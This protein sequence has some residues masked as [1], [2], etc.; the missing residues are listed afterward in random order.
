MDSLYK[1]Y[2]H[3]P[4]PPP[5]AEVKNLGCQYCTFGCGYKVYVWRVGQDGGPKPEQNAFGADFS[6]PQSAIVGTA[7]TEYKWSTIR[8]KDGWY[9]VAILPA[10]DS[11]LNL[12]GNY[13][14]R[15]GA[16]ARTTYS[17]SRPTRVRLKYPMIRV[18]DDYQPIPWDYA[19]EI[20]ARV[21]KGLLD[22]HGQAAIAAR[23]YDHGGGGG[24][25]ENNFGVWNML[26]TALQLEYVAHHNRP[27]DNSETWGSEDRGLQV[28]NYTTD[29]VRLCDTQ[30]YW[31]TNTYDTA[32]VLFAAHQLPNYQGNTV[33]EK[34]KVFSKGE[35]AAA[36]HVIVIDPRESATLGICR[37]IDRKRVLH[38]A[39]NPGTDTEL[40]NAIARICYE[41]GWYD[42]NLVESHT[43]LA[44][45]EEYKKGS[46]QIGKPLN[47]VLRRAEQ[48]TGVPGRDII[49]AAVWIAKPKKGGFMRRTHLMYEKGVIWSYRQY[50]TVAAVAQLGILTHNIGRPGTGTGRQGGHQESAALPPSMYP[51]PPKD[52]LSYLEKGGGKMFWF[53]G[54]NP[55]LTS[56]DSQLLQER[57]S[58]RA[59]TFRQ[60]IAD[61]VI[62]ADAQQLSS[63]IL[64][65]IE[66]TDGLFIVQ[67]DIYQTETG[68]DAFLL[69]PAASS[70][71]EVDMT[72]LNCSSRLLRLYEK[73]M[74]PP[75]E[76]KPDWA[77]M[78]LIGQR[79]E[80]L[81]REAGDE[82]TAKRFSG[83]TWRTAEEVFLDLQEKLWKKNDGLP[84]DR[85]NEV[86]MESFYGL[87]YDMLRKL[88]QK[89]IPVPVRVDPV[90]RK[91][92]G[93]VRLYENLRFSAPEGKARW[94]ATREWDDYR[95]AKEVHGYLKTDANRR[96]YPFW[97]LVGRTQN[98][99]Q[100][101]Y[102]QQLL[103]EKMLINPMELVQMNPEDAK[104]LGLQ[105]GDVIQVHNEQGNCNAYVVTSD[106]VRP[107]YLFALMYHPTA[108]TMNH[109]ISSF[110]DEISVNPWK[111]ATRV[112]VTR[113]GVLPE[114]TRKTSMLVTAN[115]T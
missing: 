102:H 78:G 68:H 42:P 98:L 61:P 7:Y 35:P 59:A 93:T 31:G 34:R 79:L 81:Y 92:V 5:N 57:I 103:A 3:L 110:V 32:S 55:Y 83:M 29:D 80:K 33:Q 76:A 72:S 107:G 111:K 48:I 15:G 16:N 37:S 54:C 85:V 41:R 65:V 71:G 101:A 87:N 91:V 104:R 25:F 88:G 74:D 82:K 114:L 96:R 47:A 56:Y 105:V 99:W 43:D 23:S 62:P 70:W 115:F 27:A 44:T 10:K 97:L 95:A 6:I 64:D 18:A 52:V 46:L 38:L 8:R 19:V 13:S 66:N 40:A 69:L 90:T 12:D 58:A 63:K 26:H 112:A 94:Y 77:I 20:M 106:Q 14:P 21:I 108:G 30:V 1:R 67:Q 53:V 45:F 39:L 49:R 109:L 86:F 51:R 28:L 11:P 84:A 89:G 24:G 100:T 36:S 22:K 50:D 2:D 73:F 17:P 113:L 9:N 75:G 60:A 4:L